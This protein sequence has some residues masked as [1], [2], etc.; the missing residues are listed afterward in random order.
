MTNKNKK[1]IMENLL[2]DLYS[3]YLKFRSSLNYLLVDNNSVLNDDYD[4]KRK[5]L[6]EL[7]TS[8]VKANGTSKEDIADANLKA[9]L[10]INDLETE[11]DYYDKLI[12]DIEDNKKNI[13][14]TV[15]HYNFVKKLIEK[16][17]Y[18]NDLT[19]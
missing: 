1:E 9:G 8:P 10:R 18:D 15:T 19:I 11:I 3:Q 7:R 6:K 13:K 16:K 5:E 12:K 17:E 2:N 4:K 14:E